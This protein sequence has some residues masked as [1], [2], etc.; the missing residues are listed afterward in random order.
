LYDES[1]IANVL[2]GVHLLQQSEPVLKE[3]I[4]K[5]ELIIVG[6]VYDIHSG[7]VNIISE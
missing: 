6:A 1:I 7:K 3:F 4:K 2:H 5:K